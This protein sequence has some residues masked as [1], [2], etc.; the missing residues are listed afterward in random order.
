MDA[1]TDKPIHRLNNFCKIIALSDVQWS[2]NK[3]YK[4]S[5]PGLNNEK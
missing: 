5:M 4:F 2:S 1:H 3:L